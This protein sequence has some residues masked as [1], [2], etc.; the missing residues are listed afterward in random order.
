MAT[1]SR[2]TG[3]VD[4]RTLRGDHTRRLILRRA[5]DIASVEGLEGLSIGRL[6]IE[7]EISKSG[8][9]AHFGSKEELQLA[10]IAAASEIF[11]D[12]VIKQA[13][14]APAGVRRVWRLGD[15]WL[16]YTQRRIFPGGCF[17]VT[18]A[19]EFSSRRG[20]VHDAIAA[21]RRDWHRYYE[22]TVVEA[23]YLGE[24]SPETDPTQLAFELESYG[25]SAITDTRLFDDPAP[26]QRAK[27]AMHA[28][29]TRRATNPALIPAA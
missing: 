4:G 8:V 17:M 5:A 25:R 18:V 6:A 1:L 11:V 27:S 13:H 22:S 24:L 15:A 9:F 14:L 19:A 26:Y 29:L 28:A 10:T 16:D 20:R 3:K 7:L 12:E 23:R 21:Q 2:P